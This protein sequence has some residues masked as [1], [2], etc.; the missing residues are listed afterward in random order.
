M[1]TIIRK[2]LMFVLAGILLYSC[3]KESELVLNEGSEQV[4]SA[5]E[6]GIKLGK[7]LENPYSVENMKKALQNLKKSSLTG[8]KH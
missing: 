2:I 7:K 4:I 8:K 3:Q 6:G 5:E 1:K